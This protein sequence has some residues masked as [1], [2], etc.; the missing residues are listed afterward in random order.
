MTLL[1]QST[2]KKLGLVI[3]LD[4]C[5]GCHACVVNCKE[6]NTGGHGS[7]LSDTEPY[8][9]SP[10]GAWLNRIHSFEITP[11]DASKNGQAHIVHFPKSCIAKMR[12]ASQSVR[13]AQV[14]SAR[15]TALF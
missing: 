15:K 12:P 2:E 1:P 3:D 13:P 4:V 14:T 5:V 7:P 11:Q 8:G 9:D 10:S 6:W